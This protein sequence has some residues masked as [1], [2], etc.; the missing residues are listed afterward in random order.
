MFLRNQ[1]YVAATGKELGRAL[2]ARTILGEPLVF[3]RTEAGARLA[4]HPFQGAGA[5]QDRCRRRAVG[6]QGHDKGAA[7]VGVQ[8]A[9]ARDRAQHALYFWALTR[10]FEL[11]DAALSRSKSA[12]SSTKTAGCSSSSSA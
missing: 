9:D 11:E 3:Y 2:L 6:H 12:R 1:W 8:C 7:L 5:H 4:A 10:C